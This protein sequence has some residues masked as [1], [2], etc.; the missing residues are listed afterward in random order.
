MSY[1][2]Q[3]VHYDIIVNPSVISTVW[4]SYKNQFK[5]DIGSIFNNKPDSLIAA[6]FCS[7]V[8][9]DMKPYGVCTELDLIPLLQSP[10]L[11]CDNYCVLTYH[12]YKYLYT[13]TS[14]ILVGWNNGAV[15]NHAQLL[16]YNSTFAWLLDPTIG[17]IVGGATFDNICRGQY[18][19]YQVAPTG[20]QRDPVY[21]DKI[22]NALYYG[23]YKPSDLMYYWNPI[24][25]YI[26]RPPRANWGTPQA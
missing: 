9:Y 14:L 13:D 7:I 5:T 20:Y 21:F 1:L 26:S 11:D 6:A 23:N 3:Y 10:T 16:A 18:L 19:Q 4:Q 25:K 2:P 24:S 15:G 8:A 12:L 22:K 17:L